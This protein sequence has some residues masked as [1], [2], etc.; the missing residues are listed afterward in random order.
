[1]TSLIHFFCATITIIHISR[2]NKM[3][4]DRRLIFGKISAKQ[5]LFCWPATCCFYHRFYVLPSDAILP[6]LFNRIHNSPLPSPTKFC[7]PLF[8]LFFR[9]SFLSRAFHAPLK[10]R[11][12]SASTVD[13]AFRRRGGKGRVERTLSLTPRRISSRQVT[14]SC[15][16]AYIKFHLL[17]KSI[18]FVSIIA[19]KNCIRTMIRDTI[20]DI[21][22]AEQI[23]FFG[24]LIFIVYE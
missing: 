5:K 12:I 19:R 3:S 16:I 21:F 10:R 9:L 23:L 15:Y 11:K 4:P 13:V 22:Y 1:M 24:N 6:S 17:R 8:S 20:R 2:I 18:A 7:F 14:L